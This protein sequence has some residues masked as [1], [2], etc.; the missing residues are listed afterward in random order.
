MSLF[1]MAKSVLYLFFVWVDVLASAYFT[2]IIKISDDWLVSLLSPHHLVPITSAST[3]TF[4]QV[5][6]SARDH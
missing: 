5:E 2:N 3:T 1:K 6:T 4:G